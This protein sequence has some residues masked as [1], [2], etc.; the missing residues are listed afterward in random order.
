MKHAPYMLRLWLAGP[1]AQKGPFEDRPASKSSSRVI[2]QDPARKT[3]QASLT[4]SADLDSGLSHVG[5]ARCRIVHE[6]VESGYGVNACVVGEV[7]R[8]AL[9]PGRLHG[10]RTWTNARGSR[11]STA[12]FGLCLASREAET[13]D[14][15]VRHYKSC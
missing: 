5:S 9:F 12:D 13:A 10:P 7:W 15:D 11:Y 3:E 1:L 14:L 2:S 8:H 4:D 6:P